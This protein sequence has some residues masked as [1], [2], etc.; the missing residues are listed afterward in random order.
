MNENSN[1]S[2]RKEYEVCFNNWRFFV[3]LRFT[4][5]AFFL[6]LN[7]GLLYA[8][9]NM[10]SDN[11]QEMF[12][13]LLPLVGIFSVYAGWIIENRMRQMYYA[14]IQRAKQIEGKLKYESNTEIEK[15]KRISHIWP[16][17][18][19]KKPD[20]DEEAKNN[21]IGILLDNRCP[22]TIYSWQT[23]GIRVIYSVLFAM[24]VVLPFITIP[25]LSSKLISA[26][27]LVL[28]SLDFWYC[29]LFSW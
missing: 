26:T 6:T 7:S 15:D 16:L 8:F 9:L 22:A 5:L 23:L 3:G 18:N 21:C 12:L 4:V 14:C 13:V 2:L 19:V 10:L 1:E 27:S 17:G 24:W 20:V 25:Q 11:K 28:K 29:E